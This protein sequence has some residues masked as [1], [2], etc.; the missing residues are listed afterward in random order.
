VQGDVCRGGR[1]QPVE[2]TAPQHC[3]LDREF[4]NPDTGLCTSISH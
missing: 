1:C 2:C 3:L 4:C